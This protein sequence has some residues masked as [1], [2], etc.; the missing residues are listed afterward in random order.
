MKRAALSILVVISLLSFGFWT[1]R[2]SAA[3]LKSDSQ[4]LDEMNQ[5]IAQAAQTQEVNFL[6]EM[7]RREM[8]LRITAD[9]L[10]RYAGQPCRTAD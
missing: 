3:F 2:S 8:K 1:G 4:L 7:I 10:H 6:K 9:P 5:V